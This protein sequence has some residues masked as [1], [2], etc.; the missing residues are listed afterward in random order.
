E[1]LE[2]TRAMHRAGLVGDYDVLR[3]E[4]ELANLE[5]ALRRARNEAE[6][7]RRSLAVELGLEGEDGPSVTG[8]LRSVDLSAAPSDAD[9]LL[10]TFGVEVGPTT[11]IE[12]LIEAAQ[13]SR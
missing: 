6:A 8:S 7:A 3:L 9:P 13:R 5:P 2:E 10:R 11:S 4:V 1:A 12:E